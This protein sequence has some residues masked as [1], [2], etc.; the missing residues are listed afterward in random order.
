MTYPAVYL[1]C[2]FLLGAGYVLI[3]F[4]GSYYQVFLGMIVG[5]I[6][7]GLLMP[8]SSIWLLS[9]APEHL[10]GRISGMLTTAVFL[11]QFLSPVMTQ[12][13]V[14]ALSISSLF[15]IAGAV[16]A[17]LSLLITMAVLIKR[18]YAKNLFRNKHSLNR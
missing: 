11:G 7:S 4:S 13:L 12:P 8:N 18:R 2:F 15:L 16:T 5:G 1:L 10:R 6:G 14:D 3:S 17:I 9:E